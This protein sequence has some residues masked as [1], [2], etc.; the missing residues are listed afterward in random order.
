MPLSRI[1]IVNAVILSFLP[2]ILSQEYR[3]DECKT[4]D[5][6]KG[7]CRP[8]HECPVALKALKMG[9]MPTPCGFEGRTP[10]VC[11][12]NDLTRAITPKP[13]SAAILLTVTPG[14]DEES[15]NPLD[16]AIHLS[17]TPEPIRSN[18]ISLVFAG[19]DKDPEDPKQKS[20]EIRNTTDDEVS[21]SPLKRKPGEVATYW[22]ER[23]A[24]KCRS[25]Y[26]VSVPAPRRFRAP[27]RF[28]RELPDYEDF[29]TTQ[30][31]RW[32]MG[33]KPYDDRHFIVGGEEAFLNEFPHMAAVGFGKQND[34]RWE[35]GG[36]LIS[37]KFVLTAAHCLMAR[38]G[39][40]AKWVLLGAKYVGDKHRGYS[41]STDGIIYHVIQRIRHPGYRRKSKYNDIALLELGLSLKFDKTSLNNR[42]IRPACLQVDWDSNLKRATASGWGRLGHGENPSSSLQKV[43]LN[44]L[45]NSVCNES[46]AVEI[47]L[48]KL[49]K[50]VDESM[51]CAGDLAGGKDT[52]QGDSG[53]P[54]QLRTDSCVTHIIGVTSFGKICGFAGSPAVYMKI[55]HFV[56]WIESIVWPE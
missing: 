13:K 46:Y 56:P 55:S 38:D 42:V 37:E 47:T 35:C 33:R 20:A 11:C 26:Q 4:L 22:C 28:R 34:I 51:I 50:G 18:L 49:K 19:K 40:R 54:L 25:P 9:R 21:T 7:V 32:P 15:K 53:G 6:M 48:A 44:I 27:L 8:I 5:G 2:E 16:K 39:S 43:K 23:F 31:P 29:G 52:C 36:S 24:E 17:S 30:K 12:A 1:V 41:V 14:G 10:I 45:D 3:G